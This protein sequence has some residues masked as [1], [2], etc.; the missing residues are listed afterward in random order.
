VE[1]SDGLRGHHSPERREGWSWAL[2][3]GG[4]GHYHCCHESRRRPAG[5]F[6]A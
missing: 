6:P 2:A 1:E 5:G 4:G 3:M